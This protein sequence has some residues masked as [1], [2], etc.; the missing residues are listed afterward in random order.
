MGISIPLPIVIG[1][2][3]VFWVLGRYPG[4]AAEYTKGAKNAL[5]RFIKRVGNK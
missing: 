4:K 2:A 5:V 3:V 1:V